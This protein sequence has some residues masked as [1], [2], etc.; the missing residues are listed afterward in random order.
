MSVAAAIRDSSANELGADHIVNNWGY[1]EN[2]IK[3]AGDSSE[4]VVGVAVSAFFGEET[5]P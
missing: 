1:D 4:G 2:L 3:L 5:A